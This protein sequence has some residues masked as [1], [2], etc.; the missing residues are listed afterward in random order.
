V[1]EELDLIALVRANQHVLEN[2]KSDTVTWKLKGLGWKKLAVEF[3]SKLAAN[4]WFFEQCELCGERTC[5]FT[6]SGKH[7]NSGHSDSPK[8]RKWI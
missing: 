8:I 5:N 7:H 4:A 1:D 3:S 6:R 2:K